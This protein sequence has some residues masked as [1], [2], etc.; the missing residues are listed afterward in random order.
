MNQSNIDDLITQHETWFECGTGGRRLELSDIDLTGMNL[1]HRKLHESILHGV[2]LTNCILDGTAFLRAELWD[3]SFKS[4]L[5]THCRFSDAKIHDCTFED[6]NLCHSH[7]DGVIAHQCKFMNAKVAWSLFV[8]SQLDGVCFDRCDFTESDFCRAYVIRSSFAHAN[9]HEVD[10]RQALLSDVDL[11]FS[12]MQGAGLDY[13]R[14]DR[15]LVYGISGIPALVE[16][17]EVTFP[18]FSRDGDG[19]AIQKK[20]EFLRLLGLANDPS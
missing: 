17:L 12:N 8:K 4:T 19:S 15:P 6:A 16:G 3:V 1:S 14:L 13:V 20:E 9:L 18:D 10:F 11:R 7:F 2:K 5:A